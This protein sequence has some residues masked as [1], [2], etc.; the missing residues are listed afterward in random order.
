MKAQATS[1]AAGVVSQNERA[2]GEGGCASERMSCSS[3]KEHV[4]D[5]I[6]ANIHQSS[7]ERMVVIPG[8]HY[9]P[10]EN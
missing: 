9:Y 1:D 3:C 2:R 5:V 4:K 7:A 6:C 8:H 10:A